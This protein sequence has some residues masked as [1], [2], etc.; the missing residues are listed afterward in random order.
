MISEAEYNLMDDAK[1]ATL[2][3]GCITAH[4]NQNS[5]PNTK[6]IRDILITKNLGDKINYV[7]YI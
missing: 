1:I 5:I 6:T 2:N 3:I 4:V 7:Q